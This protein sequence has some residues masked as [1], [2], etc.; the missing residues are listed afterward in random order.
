MT[1]TTTIINRYIEELYRNGTVARWNREKARQNGSKEGQ[2][3]SGKNK[4]GKNTAAN[5]RFIRRS[6]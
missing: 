5:R 1:G 6:V 2:R 3:C 4:K